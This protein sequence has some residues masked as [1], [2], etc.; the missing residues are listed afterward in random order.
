LKLILASASASRARL[1]A[2][3]GVSFSVEPA[4]LDED[5]LRTEHSDAEAHLLARTLAAAK[6]IHVSRQ[7]IGDLVLGADQLVELD[8]H[9]ISKCRNM[10]E[11]GGLIAEL[12]GKTHRLHSALVLARDGVVK[13]EHCST[14]HLTMRNF[15]AGFLASYTAQA[16]EEIL[17]CVG[18]YQLEGLGSQLFERIDG[19]YF[20]ILGLPLLPLLAALRH[21]GVIS[22]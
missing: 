7:K 9:I 15:S 16:G 6:A 4:D 21:E 20:S 13:W 5:S 3:A 14:A 8:G 17:A 10:K 22:T 1:L 12:G 18:C 11:A 2:A 19:D